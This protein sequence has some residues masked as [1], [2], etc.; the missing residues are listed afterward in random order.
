[1][2]SFYYLQ[3]IFFVQK[4]LRNFFRVKLPVASTCRLAAASKKD[5]ASKKKLEG[6]SHWR[7][8]TEHSGAN[9]FLANGYG[10]NVEVRRFLPLINSATYI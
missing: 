6:G 7:Q 9:K 3:Q 5:S 4:R 8:K 2:S 1:M 10:R